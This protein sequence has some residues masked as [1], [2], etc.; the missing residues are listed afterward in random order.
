MR[1]VMGTPL[2]L[3]RRRATFWGGVLTEERLWQ[4]CLELR[5]GALVGVRPCLHQLQGPLDHMCKLVT[6]F[7]LFLACRA[8]RMVSLGKVTAPKPVNLPSQK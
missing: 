2:V 8:R 6:P 1:V 3:C 5:Q 7:H 4:P